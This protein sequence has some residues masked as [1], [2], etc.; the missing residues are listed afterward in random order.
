MVCAEIQYTPF[1][2]LE[3]KMKLVKQL[4]F[5]VLL[6]AGL[7]VSAKPVGVWHGYSDS[8][9]W[10]LLRATV[11][12]PQWSMDKPVF[13]NFTGKE[14]DKV[15]AIV[16]LHGKDVLR[17][18]EVKPDMVKKLEDFVAQGGNFIVISDGGF[19]GSTK[20][21]T[22]AKL[23]GGKT[24]SILQGKVEI[25]D[26]NW[27]DCG[28]NPDVFEHMLA[29]KYVDN[30]KLVTKKIS[31]L[32]GL[33]TARPVIG[34]ASGNLV[35]VNKFGK[36]K[37]WFIN[38]CLS[39]S[40]TSYKQPYHDRANAALE[41]YYPFAKKIHEMLMECKPE[42][43]KEKRELWNPVPL[44]PKMSTVKITPRI[45]KVLVSA[46][47]YT[48]LE[49]KE[50]PLVVDG[51]PQAL[52]IVRKVGERGAFETLNRVI[53]QMS[54]TKLPLPVPR[55][56][57]EKD[58][59]WMWKKQPY[60]TKIILETADFVNIK[61]QGNLIT[62][63]APN[64]SLGI[65]T[66]MR[67][68]LNYRMLWPGRDGEVF[69]KTRNIKIASSELY[70]KSPIRQRV[71][72][73]GLSCGKYPW[74][75][76]NGEVVQVSARPGMSKGCDILG[77]DVR[78]VVKLRAGHAAWNAPQRL[79]GSLRTGGGA[80]FYSWREKYG[81]TRPEL[82]AL[83]FETVRKMKTKHVRI[84]KSNPE[85]V[86][87]AVQEALENLK[88]PRYKNVEYYRFSPSDG[89]YD[90]MCMCENCRKWDCS[91]APRKTTRVFIGA[92][93]PVYRYV[94]MTDRV[95][96]F[97]CE[98]ARELQKYRPD[99]KVA[100]L[101]Y[102][103]YLAPPYYYHDLPRNMLITF[104]GGE[105]FNS[106][107]RKRDLEYWKYWSGVA[108]ELCWRPNFLG[109]GSG[110]PLMYFREMAKDLKYFASTGMVGGDFDTLPH[111]WATNALN[112]YVLA[113]LL[114]DPALPVDD[115]V[116]DFCKSGFGK[117]ADSM[118][119]YYAH[120]EKLTQKY[121]QLGGESIKEL[122]D[123]TVVPTS[124]FGRFC[125]AFT[126]EEFKKLESILTEAKGKVAADSPEARRIEF[127]GVGLEFFKKN[128]EFAMKYWQTP[129]KERKKLIPEIDKLV[130]EWK[131]MFHKY[132]FAINVTS[133]TAGYFYT[134]FRNCGWK[135]IHQ[136]AK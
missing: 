112:Y 50:L 122:E 5:A 33:T 34:N 92:N 82:L 9:V 80:N 71:L 75:M 117:A 73:N 97:T 10:G 62:I 114:W 47:K 37:V 99:M 109:G 36:G 100:Y 113:R 58:G 81:K 38:V 4:F 49:D 104:V 61:A 65:Q 126:A 13:I 8:R 106:A 130:M 48:K 98:A 44:G 84:C 32:S 45:P 120:C 25:L 3:L 128:R 30:G 95:L 83:Q 12:N 103:G 63:T 56:V 111:H 69:T 77:L 102:A 123:L 135:P 121:I 27:K 23:L 74:K 26:E 72:R 89:G 2:L 124:G 96:R 136:Y 22:L 40:Y 132:P 15:S 64:A 19:P 11:F 125:R 57:S 16:Y 76:P 52:L 59:V 1:F 127:V 88:R 79:G 70:D 85:T 90:I 14:F 20:T 115:I 107:N 118:K 18:R 93:R 6:L 21:G 39:N 108:N 87:L 41:Q 43:S 116:D 29:P 42:L 28:K 101:A 129:G 67:E 7:A 24:L 54:G 119:K 134:F 133:L 60:H 91:D 17:F 110:M 66:F 68:Y 94:S 35:T 105:Y 31:A 51:K 46:R 131:E 78:E 53:F 55:T 86:K